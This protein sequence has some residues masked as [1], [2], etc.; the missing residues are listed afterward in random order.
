MRL[1]A[2][3]L[4][5]VILKPSNC[6]TGRGGNKAKKFIKPCFDGDEIENTCSNPSDSCHEKLGTE[7]KLLRLDGF[8][9]KCNCQNYKYSRN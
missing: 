3:F 6:I 7:L 8:K 5:V 9:V 4:V 2:L 1:L